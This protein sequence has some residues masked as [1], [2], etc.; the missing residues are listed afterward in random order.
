MIAGLLRVIDMLPYLVILWERTGR[1]SGDHRLSKCG[2][3]ISSS[4]NS[5]WE[6]RRYVNSQAPPQSY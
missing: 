4:S 5:T 3:Q 1:N 2:S 6:L